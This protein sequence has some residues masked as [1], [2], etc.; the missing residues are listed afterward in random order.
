M[1][2]T[3]T[4]RTDMQGDLSIG[5]DQSVFT[6]DELDRFYERAGSD[7]NT[8]VYYGWRQIL[9]GSAKWVDY[10]VAQTKVSRSQAF[11]QI[12]QMV[13]FWAAESKA[14]DDQ[15][16]SA[17]IAPVPTQHKPLPADHSAR[18]DG[19]FRRGRWYPYGRY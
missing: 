2:L 18:S 9:A 8:A 19:Y 11:A 17:G 3:T 12:K 1:S 10:Q 5:S 16:L 14:A 13:D 6:N 15:L 7:Y 4:Q